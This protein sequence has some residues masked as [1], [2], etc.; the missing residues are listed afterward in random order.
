MACRVC[1]FWFVLWCVVSC[2]VGVFCCQRGLLSVRSGRQSYSLDQT[3]LPY[4]YARRNAYVS[5]FFCCKTR[6][7]SFHDTILICDTI[8]LLVPYYVLHHCY[9]SLT[10]VPAD[11]TNE[12]K[13]IAY[14]LVLRT[15]IVVNILITSTQS[16]TLLS[17]V[18]YKNWFIRL[19]RI[20][21]L[22]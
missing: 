22:N 14:F 8:C 4:L 13:I 9:A 10:T 15:T 2:G 6:Y 16:T 7:E 3:S 1:S 18:V 20:S 5:C 11:D 17:P 12:L 21:R 19:I